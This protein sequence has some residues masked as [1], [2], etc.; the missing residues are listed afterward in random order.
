M[1][2]TPFHPLCIRV[3]LPFLYFCASRLCQGRLAP[4]ARLLSALPSSCPPRSIP[5]DLA[6]WKRLLLLLCIA[7]IMCEAHGA[8]QAHARTMVAAGVV[9][10]LV[11]LLALRESF[12]TAGHVTPIEWGLYLSETMGA[13]A[14]LAASSPAARRQLRDAGAAPM[15]RAIVL[16]PAAR[17]GDTLRLG[18][19]ALR[20]LAPRS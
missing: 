11:A 4:P 10:P 12:R 3:P 13:I 18:C 7:R 20:C 5:R 14:A 6:S 15:L 19:A 8:V 2:F 17:Q 16:E 9:P 1:F